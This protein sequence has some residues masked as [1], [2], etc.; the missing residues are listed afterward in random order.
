MFKSATFQR[1]VFATLLLAA[2][3]FSLPVWGQVSTG[4]LSGTVTDATGAVVPQASIVLKNQANNSTR[5]S[6]ANG[7]GFFNF[8]AVQPA[9]YMVTVS[10]PGFNSWEE[11]DIVFTQ[12]ANLTLPNIVMQI[13]STQQQV[14][15]VSASDVIV[16]S[17]TGQSSQTLSTR[18]ITDLAIQ[19]RDAA[20]L[21]KIMPG[22][23]M[24]NGLSQGM[25]S[26]LV[27]QSNTGPIG[28]FSAQG[29]QPY[30]GM[31][32]TSD[33]ANLRPGQSGNPDL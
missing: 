24:N 25:F 33:G 19:G 4:S 18:M 21:I 12:A 26:S 2:V 17:D 14:E 32:M 28:S 1:N 29:T 16:P 9:T 10:A 30:G 22:M 15:V 11:K 23:G 13:A 3:V 6:V 31:T 27:T 5:Q 20:E 7:S 8:V